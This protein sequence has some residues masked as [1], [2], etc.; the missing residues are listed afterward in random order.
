MERPKGNNNQH[1]YCKMGA[2]VR[3]FHLDSQRTVSRASNEQ[4][5]T[6]SNWME[7]KNVNSEGAAHSV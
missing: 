1:L 5:R 3:C 2:Q 6:T 7:A 4:S